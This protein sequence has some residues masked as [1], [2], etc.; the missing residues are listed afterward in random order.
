[1][2]TELPQSLR[3]LRALYPYQFSNPM[4]GVEVA[5]GWMPVFAQLCADVDE[6]L[7]QDKFGFHWSQIK[8]KFGSARFYYRFQGREPGIRLDLHMP[9]GVWSQ[10]IPVKR[11]IRT[12]R[13]KTFQE[14]DQAVL[15]LTLAAEV[16]TQSMCLICGQA[17]VPDTAGGYVMV[18]CPQH[19]AQRR[20][21]S[22]LPRD[23]W[24]HLEE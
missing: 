15:K 6:V 21:A 12:E 9:G 23:F 7:G 24:E 14:I 2:A 1:M 5:K 20:Q 11:R 4:L 8:E 3:S 16:A 18:L 10:H 17:G 22:G 13:D 19:Q